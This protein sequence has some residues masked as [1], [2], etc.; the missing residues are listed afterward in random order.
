MTYK[1]LDSFRFFAFLSVF[2]Y[3][4]GVLP[5]GYVGV[6]AFF[7]L[8]GFLLTP[9]LVGMRSELSARRYFIN[10]YGRRALR[11]FPLAYFYLAMVGGAAAAA[12]FISSL[13]RP[14]ARAAGQ[15]GFAATYTYDFFHASS[16]YV[17]SPFLT[18]FWSLAVE[19]QFY[20]VWPVVVLCASPSQLRRVL[21][22]LIIAGPVIRL[23]EAGLFTTSFASYL[24]HRRDLT[25]YVLPFSHVDAFAMGGY[26]ALFGRTPSSPVVAGYA[27]CLMTIGIVTERLVTGSVTLS[28]FGYRPFMA[29]SWKYAWAYSALYLLF[30]WILLMIRDRAFFPLLM[31]HRVPTYLGRI[32][33]GLYVYHFA[34]LWGMSQVVRAVMPHSPDLAGLTRMVCAFG[35]AVG[36]SM[37][38][39]ALIER[40]L[41]RLKDK[42]FPKTRGRTPV[43]APSDVRA[44]PV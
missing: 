20:L 24:Y 31:E 30:G 43:V 10:F 6:L 33:Y 14:V 1:G 35:I 3:H 36:A 23:A 42:H 32:S 29:D 25:I 26:L 16:I 17:H 18:H 19:E 15:L 11:I 2:L 8:S 39:Y 7:V 21:V 12:H 28:A 40:P 34:A 4:V 13:P 37:V 27:A 44:Q 9:I 41:L 22:A 38:S 5:A